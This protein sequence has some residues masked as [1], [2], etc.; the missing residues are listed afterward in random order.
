MKKENKLVNT[1][2]GTLFALDVALR[3]YDR[4]ESIR[5]KRHLRKCNKNGKFSREPRR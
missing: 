4:F 3:V 5:Y 1:I 2:L